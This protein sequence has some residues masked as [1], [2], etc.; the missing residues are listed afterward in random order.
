MTSAERTTKINMIRS[1]PREAEASVKGLTE[2]QLNTPYREGGWTPRQVIHHLADSHLNAFIRMKLILTEENPTIK[3]YDQEKWA[4]LSDALR[5]P[6]DESLSILKGLHA[7]WVTLM[8]QAKESDW[9]RPAL[10]PESGKITLESLL[11]T[12]SKHGAN[13]VGQIMGLRAAKGW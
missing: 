6:V 8:E 13:H 9:S 3:P 5:T 4:E 2:E 7:R 12:Y 10:H 1:L 11:N